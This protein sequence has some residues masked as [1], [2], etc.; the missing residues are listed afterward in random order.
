M[1]KINKLGLLAIISLSVLI[2]LVFTAE[3]DE[4]YQLMA[5]VFNELQLDK[6]ETITRDDLKIIL[7]RLI[8]NTYT[9]E[10]PDQKNMFTAVVEKYVLSVP[11]NFPRRDVAKYLSQEV[12]M[13]ILQD[14]IKEQLGDQFFDTL[15]PALHAEKQK[16][17]NANKEEFGN[18]NDNK[19][20]L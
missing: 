1:T 15:K 10:F 2:G 17:F 12:L 6:K 16:A 4:N 5:E 3:E 8:G 9:A 14:V 13:E 7:D 19:I 20:E 11:D 18:L